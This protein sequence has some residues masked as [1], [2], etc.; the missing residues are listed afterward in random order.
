MSISEVIVKGTYKKA[1][2]K[3]ETGTVKFRPALWQQST[4]GIDAVLDSSGSFQTKFPSSDS[5]NW[6]DGLQIPYRVTVAVS[7]GTYVKELTFKSANSPIDLPTLFP[8]SADS[9]GSGGG[10][11]GVP[12]AHA[13]THEVGG[14]DPLNALAKIGNRLSLPEWEYKTALYVNCTGELL[15]DRVRVT[16]TTASLGVGW[17]GG[18]VRGEVPVTPGQPVTVHA[19]A[20]TQQADG[21]RVFPRIYWWS[22]GQSRPSSSNQPTA[23]TDLTSEWLTVTHT[24]VAPED[25]I[26]ASLF[27]NISSVDVGEIFDIRFPGLWLGAGGEIRPPGEPIPGLG[28]RTTKLNNAE[29]LSV[30]QG[31]KWAPLSGDTGTFTVGNGTI[32]RVGNSVYLTATG[33][34]PPT[35]FRPA[36]GGTAPTNVW[37]V[38]VDDW[39]TSAPGSAKL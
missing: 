30:W 29:L 20:R 2:G 9:G 32:R 13:A 39:P 33:Y 10:G 28:F 25:A 26:A 6:P 16:A 14:S 15:A 23:G 36:L 11:S 21:G 22:A 37:Y 19:Q 27:V 4:S 1:D 5:G 8:I 3:P 12:A 17:V 18:T 35:G 7:S 31:G 34:T 38:T 24:A